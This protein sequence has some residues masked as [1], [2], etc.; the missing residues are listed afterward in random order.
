MIRFEPPRFLDQQIK[1][2][3]AQQKEKEA[4][5][6]D[7]RQ[8]LNAESTQRAELKDEFTQHLGATQNL[9]GDLAKRTQV[10]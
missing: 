1:S 8:R 7:L 4:E 5:V 9:V 10:R 6:A 3:R 2:V